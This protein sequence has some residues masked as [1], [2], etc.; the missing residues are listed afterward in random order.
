MTAVIDAGVVPDL[1]EQEYHHHPALSVSGAKKLLPPSCPAIF[2]WERDNPP[3]PKD[4]F[5]LGSAAHKLVLGVGCDLIEVEADDW[6]TAAAKESRAEARAR[7]AVALLSKDMRTVEA[8]AL[9]LRQH[10]IASALLH[11]TAGTP[12][13]SMFWTDDETGVALRGRVDFLPDLDAR[14]R[15]ILTD[16]K[17]AQS[18]YPHKFAKDAGNYRYHMQA[19]FYLDGVRALG[20]ADDA[21]FLFVVQEKVAPYLVS[22][23]ELDADALAE[24]Q[25]KNR[26]AIDLYAACVAEDYWPSYTDDVALVSIPGWAA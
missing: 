7:G 22:V 16:Y 21:A 10:P 1:D 26:D 14:D 11:R 12:E 18:A 15:L 2:K 23:V 17:T 25:S 6:R 4:V 9:A 5:D 13:A 20:L 19:A 24:G 3:E 8:M